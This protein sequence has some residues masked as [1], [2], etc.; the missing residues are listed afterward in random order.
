[1]TLLFDTNFYFIA[2]EFIES[3]ISSSLWLS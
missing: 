3:K 2:S 1:L